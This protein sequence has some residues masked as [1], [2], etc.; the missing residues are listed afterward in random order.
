MKTQ[1]E[2]EAAICEG[3]NHFERDHMGRGPKNIHAHLIGDLI[4]VR[5]QGVLT[6]AE[7]QLVKTLSSDKGRDLLK[8]VRSQLMETARPILEAMVQ[9]AAGVKALSLQPRYQ[10]RDRRRSRT[11]HPGPGA[12]VS[13]N[14]KEVRPWLIA[15]A[16][17]FSGRV[18]T[19]LRCLHGSCYYVGRWF[20]DV[21]HQ[22]REAKNPDQVIGHVD[23]PPDKA[24]IG[25]TL[26]VMMVVVPALAK[27]E[28]GDP[29]VVAT[30]VGGGIAPTSK[31]VADRID[32]ESRV[33]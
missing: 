3:M 32:R 30:R 15:H 5:L 22:S 11:F 20:A 23:L 9:E 8:Q 18:W 1:G 17:R 29:P 27:S 24:L 19:R 25:G 14:E 4:V 12:F 13:R 31:E 21:P 10:H 28:E 33:K 6:A 2:I 16:H 7:Q 26:V